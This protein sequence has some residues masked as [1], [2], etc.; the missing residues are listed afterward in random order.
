VESLVKWNIQSYESVLRASSGALRERLSS[1]CGLLKDSS[2][3]LS[4]CQYGGYT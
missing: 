2:M 1:T 3:L 4:T